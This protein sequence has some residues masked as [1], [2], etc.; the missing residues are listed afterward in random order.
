M[1]TDGLV[2]CIARCWARHGRDASISK[3]I[4][5]SIRKLVD[6]NIARADGFVADDGPKLVVEFITYCMFVIVQYLINSDCEL[7]PLI[8]KSHFRDLVPVEVE[9]YLGTVQVHT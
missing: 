9:G 5:I 8:L 4:Y 7:L 6:G 1:D 3:G 2:F